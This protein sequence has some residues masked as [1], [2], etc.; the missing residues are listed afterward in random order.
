MVYDP[1]YTVPFCI[2]VPPLGAVN[3]PKNTYPES[4]AP[5]RDA[6]AA[7]TFTEIEVGETVP[8]FALSV[9]V[10]V[11]LTDV[12]VYVGDETPSTVAVSLIVPVEDAEGESVRTPFES[13][14]ATPEFDIVHCTPVVTLRSVPRL[15]VT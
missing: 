12:T 15:S 5:G 6:K 14:Y 1:S 4:V 9:I 10:F 11:G 13:V 8:P 2:L 3:H 7:P